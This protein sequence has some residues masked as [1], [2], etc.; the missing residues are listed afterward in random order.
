MSGFDVRLADA[1]RSRALTFF[2]TVAVGLVLILVLAWDHVLLVLGVGGL[3]YAVALAVVLGSD[4]V[5]TSCSGS[6]RYS[7][8]PTTSTT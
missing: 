4:R 5:R 6:R 7:D 2:S 1:R 8:S 3:G